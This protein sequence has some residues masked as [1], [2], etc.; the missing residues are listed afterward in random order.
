[1]PV[2]STY[3]H[4]KSF[5]VDKKATFLLDTTHARYHMGQLS[6]VYEVRDKFCIRRHGIV[7]NMGSIGELSVDKV[8]RRNSPD[9]GEFLHT[10]AFP[11]KHAICE[12]YNKINP[13][14]R[15][16]VFHFPRITSYI[17]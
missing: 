15:G 6:C 16:I 3:I 14:H 4:R 13:W 5:I 1:M 9:T 2:V 8:M 11:D 12:L 7:H 17:Q 10:V